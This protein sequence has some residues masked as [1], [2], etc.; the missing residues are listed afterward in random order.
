MAPE[1]VPLASFANIP[2]AVQFDANEDFQ[3]QTHQQ[4]LDK[5]FLGF[6]K[7]SYVRTSVKMDTMRERELLKTLLVD[8]SSSFSNSTIPDCICYR[9]LASLTDE[10][11]QLFGFKPE[12]HRAEMLQIF[13]EMGNQDPSYDYLC[14]SEMAKEYNSQIIGKA[15]EHTMALCS[16]FENANSRMKMMPVED[17]V[18]GDK[19]YASRFA[20]ETL[21]QMSKDLKKI[22][23]TVNE[24]QKIDDN[25]A[26]GGTKKKKLKFVTCAYYAAMALGLSCAW[27]WWWSKHNGSARLDRISLS[28]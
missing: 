3:K 10:D 1:Y 20:L 13:A 22:E 9:D 27:F 14:N 18:V 2:S 23:K 28:T 7:R 24:L 12:Q 4:K 11:L 15:T 19:R 25:Q 8:K 6:K 16:S 26:N 21:E 5:P 17:L